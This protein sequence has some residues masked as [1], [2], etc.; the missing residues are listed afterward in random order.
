MFEKSPYLLQHA[1]N[2]VDWYPWGPEAFKKA[3]DEDKPVFLSIGYS[4][5]HWCHVMEKECFE[6]SEVARLLNDVFVCIKVDREERPDLDSVYMKVCQTLTGSGGW[7]LHI[8]MTPDKKPFFAA[9]YIPKE[10]RFGQVGM[11]ELIPKIMELW[12]T[13]RNELLESASK[14]TE[15]LEENETGS[16]RASAASEE[17]G[18]S[19]MDEA[20]FQLSE[21]FDDRNGG[22]G[23]APKFPS[24]H[25]LTFLLRYWKRTSD[26]K[27]LEMVEKTLKAMRHGG[28]YDQLGFGFHRYSTDP[29]WLVPHFE[30]MLY[31]QALLAIAITEAYQA[32]G[33]AE[34]MQ[35]AREIIAY[36]LRDMTDA[37][38][39]FYS[40]EDADSEGEEGKFY[41]WTEEEIRQLL[42]EDEADF[43]IKI[44]NV[45]REGNFEE[46]LTGGK[47]GTNILHLEKSPTQIASDT[48]VPLQDAQKR[49]DRVQRRLFDAREKRVRPGKDDKILV[50]WNGLMIVALSKAAQVFN[51]PEYANAAKRAADF[52][53]ESMRDAQS[54]LYHRYRDG[55]AKVTG[56]LSDYAFFVWGLV[57][58]YET[59]FDEE[60]LQHAVELTERMM[61]HF[62]DERQG[63]FYQTAD[64][65]DVTL[66]RNKEIYDGALP[67][68][69][70]VACLTLIRLAHMTGETRYEEEA[71]QLMRSFS[72]AVSR[73]PSAC[74]QLLIALDFAIGPSCEVVVVGESGKIDT[75]HMLEALR[76][77]F[78]PR[79]VVLL[80]SLLGQRHGMPYLDA[81]TGGLT[82]KEGIATAYVCCN[83][84]CKPPTTNPDKMLEQIDS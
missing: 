31:D 25:N 17:L 83:H 59:V 58:L 65:A 14:V 7:P 49:L 69:N 52:I 60:Y 63:G 33:D 35:T 73:A 26:A 55:E 39:G 54:G 37:A 75:K 23:N 11:K 72:S 38:G 24:P 78:A 76:S 5:C 50:D 30:K 3:E 68:G 2:P 32:T 20:Y 46:A 64:D 29:R 10:N 9:T 43:A 66:V 28:V 84:V 15:L 18:A 62:W 34:Y 77:R 4:T 40:A 57:E 51:E 19:T 70:S 16:Q 12:A 74:T 21:S 8:I 53:L 45:K 1:H 36:V 6:D 27:A 81:F 61:K 22:F 56:F 67:S 79:K 41:L 48:H 71:T 44:F 42:P 47:T 82:S 13:R 80:S